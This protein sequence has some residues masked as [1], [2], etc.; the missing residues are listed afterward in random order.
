LI[1]LGPFTSTQAQKAIGVSQPTL[2]RWVGEGLIERIARGL[3]LHPKSKVDPAILDFIIACAKFKSKAAV[4]GL[5]A[6]YHY[7][8]I[9]QPPAQVW[10]LVPAERVNRDTRYRCL[11][12]TTSFQYGIN[13][14]EH[15]N[16]TNLE[17]S[18]LEGFKY[19]TK[20][21]ERTAIQAARRA[22]EEGLTTETKLGKM[23]TFLK[24]RKVLEKYWEAI[25]A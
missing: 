21:G 11:R 3:Y 18:I 15:Y 4:G 22:L 2:S 14:H 10:V 23:A 25:V 19:S 8:L 7:G 1:P 20:I 16:I 12:T 5:S 6:L 24:L 17:R 13:R 9:N